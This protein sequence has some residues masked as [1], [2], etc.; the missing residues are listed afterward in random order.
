[1]W[2]KGEMGG[3]IDFP[4]LGTFL[5]FLEEAKTVD[6]HHHHHYFFL[7]LFRFHVIKTSVFVSSLPSK[8]FIIYRSA[9]FSL[10][11]SWSL[12]SRLV[13][14]ERGGIE[15]CIEFF[16]SFTFSLDVCT[17]IVIVIIIQLV[18]SRFLFLSFWT[19]GLAG[20]GCLRKWVFG[21]IVLLVVWISYMNM[22]VGRPVGRLADGMRIVD[23]DR[24]TD[25]I[26]LSRLTIPIHET[27]PQRRPLSQIRVARRD[28]A[29]LTQLPSFIFPSLRCPSSCHVSTKLAFGSSSP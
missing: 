24:Y 11:W 14:L 15:T 22:H 18:G 27:K 23:I 10:F 9:L 13:L 25:S 20:F 19:K 5:V 28:Q 2:G 3:L 6:P 1:M 26:E 16:T 17:I 12:S 29:S 8:S 21:W 4:L 7:L